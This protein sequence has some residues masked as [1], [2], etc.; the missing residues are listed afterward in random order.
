MKRIVIT[1]ADGFVGRWAVEALTQRFPGASLILT[2]RG[3]WQATWRLPIEASIERLDVTE[4]TAVESF[5]SRH[6]PDGVLHLAGIS[7]VHDA[8]A[9]VLR[10]Y[11]VNL[12]GT[13]HLAQ[14]LLTYVPAA[15]LVHVGSADVY[16][17]TLQ[18]SAMPLAEDAVIAPLNAYSL[19]K[20][21]GDLTL[22][23]AA[24]NGLQVIRLRPFNHIGPGQDDR[25]VVSAFAR[26]IAEIEAG[27]REPVMKV[28]DLSA[29]RE[30]LDVRDVA[31][32]YALAFEA[33]A[34]CWRGTVV[35]IAGGRRICIG[36]MLNLLL[37]LS[38][39]KVSVLQDAALI[40][41]A[42]TGYAGGNADRARMMLDWQPVIPFEATLSDI[43]AFWR[44]RIN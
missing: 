41:R 21:A 29:T 32:A 37:S 4:Q 42:E 24:A 28:G 43:L 40:R 39:A 3:E 2:T 20:A 19:S 36:D 5:I 22:G 12:H 7:A 18:T 8:E 25:F 1:G 6:R 17:A 27:R 14:S 31:R 10:A 13:R 23:A 26:Q 44:S 34:P 35:N 16:G 9:D 15:R 38:T 30:F 11:D 33:P